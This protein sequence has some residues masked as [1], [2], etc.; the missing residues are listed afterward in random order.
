MTA[1]LENDLSGTFLEKVESQ[2]NI[3]EPIKRDKDDIASIL[4][5]SGTTGRSK[6]AMLTHNNLVSNTK[7]LFKIW[8]FS[9]NESSLLKIQNNE[10]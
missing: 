3:F 8:K 9:D 2:K 10:Y 4:Y 6:G 1:Q 5:T 7:S